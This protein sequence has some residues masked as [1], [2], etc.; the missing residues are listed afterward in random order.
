MWDTGAMSDSPSTEILQYDLEIIP[1]P[2]ATVPGV[3][4]LGLG[5]RGGA[6]SRAGFMGQASASLALTCGQETPASQLKSRREPRA[7]TLCLSANPKQRRSGVPVLIGRFSNLLMVSVSC[8]LILL[9]L[10]PNT[11]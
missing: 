8:R 1:G 2:H 3:W 9:R 4:T 5:T 10:P 7:S 11:V 6:E